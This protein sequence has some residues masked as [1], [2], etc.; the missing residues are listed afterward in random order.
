MK[1]FLA[2]VLP[3]EILGAGLSLL[4][5]NLL[6]RAI[7]PHF[8]LTS[9]HI[10]LLCGAL[11]LLRPALARQS[12]SAGWWRQIR[13][14]DN[15]PA[16]AALLQA[17]LWPPVIMATV[18]L[19]LALLRDFFGWL[20]RKPA[21]APDVAGQKIEFMQKSQYGTLLLMGLISVLVDIPVNA[22]IV[23]VLVDDPARRHLIHTVLLIL[24]LYL[25]MLVLGD[26]W[27]IRRQYHVLSDTHLHLRLGERFTADIQLT[28]IN[29][30]EVFD[31]SVSA[32]RKEHAIS[33]A[34]LA[35]ACPCQ[36]LDQPNLLLHLNP[37]GQMNQ[38][39][40]LRPNPPWLLLFVDHP[41]QVA[42]NIGYHQAKHHALAMQEQAPLDLG[43]DYLSREQA[44]A[45]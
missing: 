39:H 4:L 22:L 24:T 32:W 37:G 42:S 45:R 13:Q 19:H 27:K 31:G 15:W 8:P 9:K 16:R 3:S 36:T 34:Q 41:Q 40:W 1:T 38:G 30:I 23:G 21:P 20:R 25:S 35:T 18:R 29:Q 33:A 26:R 17:L 28:D 7:W 6:L 11:L 5:V 43:G 10:L 2:N 12:A 14:A 44:H